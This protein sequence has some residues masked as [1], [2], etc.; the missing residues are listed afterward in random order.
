MWC[1]FRVIDWDGLSDEDDEDVQEEEVQDDDGQVCAHVSVNAEF[2]LL[3]PSL[4][5]HQME[6]KGKRK[7]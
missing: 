1:V 3:S 7:R 2:F 4:C 5:S 6:H